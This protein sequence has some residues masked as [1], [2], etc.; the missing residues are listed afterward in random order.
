MQT[1]AFLLAALLA[2]GVAPARGELD[3]D[4]Y[5][6]HRTVFFAILEGLYLDGVADED[7]DRILLTDPET[8]QLLHFVPDCPLCNPARDA[9]RAYRARLPF[10]GYKHFPANGFGP[11]LKTDVKNALRSDDF[12]ARF[13]AIQGLIERWVRRRITLMRL[14]PVERENWEHQIADMRKKGMSLLKSAG[15]ELKNQKGC[16]ICDGVLAPFK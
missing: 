15:G 4:A 6:H 12:N 16:A 10:E 2:A 1:R 14:T 5:L 11:G 9:L 7:V 8:K 3:K 13:V